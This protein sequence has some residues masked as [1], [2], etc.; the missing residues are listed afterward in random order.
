MSSEERDIFSRAS[1]AGVVADALSA[2]KRQPFKLSSAANELGLD[3]E[4]SSDQMLALA[5]SEP[6][7]YFKLRSNI[8]KSLIEQGVNS[9][10]ETYYKLLSEGLY[11][12]GN[13]ITYDT[14]LQK[15]IPY[16][17]NLPESK[18]SQLALSG[19]NMIKEFSEKIV[20]EI[21]PK[22]FGESATQKSRMLLKGDYHGVI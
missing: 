9:M 10:Y 18:V 12:N 14:K 13:Q 20:N 17:P 16:N 7:E 11:E 8:K 2:Q 6:N 21:L 5:L 15:G 3:S 4:L 22:S 19:A 1:I